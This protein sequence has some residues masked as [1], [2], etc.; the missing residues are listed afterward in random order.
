MGSR[1]GVSAGTYGQWEQGRRR[2]SEPTM[3]RMCEAFECIVTVR[4]DGV[5]F[6]PIDDGTIVML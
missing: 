3:T 2:M 4:I 5:F 6:T 1:L